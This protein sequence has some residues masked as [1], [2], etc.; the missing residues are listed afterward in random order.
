MGRACT[1]SSRTGA[2]TSAC[3]AAMRFERKSS[4]SSIGSANA[5]VLPEPVIAEPTMS[6]PASA[7]GTH[8]AWMGVGAV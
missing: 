4:R 6:R 3:V 7:S 8:A 2:S 1:A 5:A